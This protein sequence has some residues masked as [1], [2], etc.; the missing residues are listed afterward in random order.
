MTLQIGGT[1]PISL[2]F[3]SPSVDT[4]CGL[5]LF[6]RMVLDIEA[7]GPGFTG[8][9]QNEV[10]EMSGLLE[11][12]DECMALAKLMERRGLEQPARA[13]R[14]MLDSGSSYNG[15]MNAARYVLI[16]TLDRARAAC[17]D[18]ALKIDAVVAH[19]DQVRAG[20]AA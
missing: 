15:S 12:R 20:Q 6:M 2:R 3:R 1:P 19:I 7:K 14:E 13:L 5:I 17:P 11:V 18:V 4:E 9:V 10:K 8:R 16:N